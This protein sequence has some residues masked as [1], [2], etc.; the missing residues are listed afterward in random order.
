M[1]SRNAQVRGHIQ[2]LLDHREVR[3]VLARSRRPSSI[4]LPIE[5]AL[6]LLEPVD[7]VGPF[8][9]VQVVMV[10]SRGDVPTAAGASC[11]RSLCHVPSGLLSSR[12]TPI[13]PCS[14]ASCQCIEA[15]YG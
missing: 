15:S 7:V 14:D 5:R 6:V 10:G 11:L 1:D 13:Q 8:L 2:V 4:R 12:T 9:G 3:I